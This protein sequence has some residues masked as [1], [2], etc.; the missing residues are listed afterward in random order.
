MPEQNREL[1]SALSSLEQN[2]IS[3]VNYS[4]LTLALRGLESKDPITRIAI[5]QSGATGDSRRLA[6]LLLADPLEEEQDWELKLVENDADARSLLITY[7]E[8]ADY[9]LSNPLLRVLSVPAPVL[10]K[11]RIEI[12]LLN[13]NAVD[14]SLKGGRITTEESLVTRVETPISTTGRYSQV[15]YPVHKAVTIGSGLTGIRN[16][17]SLASE[18]PEG[19]VRRMI[20]A[21]VDVPWQNPE[22]VL[23]EDGLYVIS[24][25][26]AEKA[27]AEIRQ[28]TSQSISYEHDW[29][30]SKVADI[31]GFMLDGTLPSTTVKPAHRT[32]ISN[33]ISNAQE[34]LKA[35][36]AK[37]ASTVGTIEDVA[38]SL[39]PLED[40]ISDW[41]ERAHTELRD[42]L[43]NAFASR[44]WRKLAWYKL[45]F[46]VDDVSMIGSDIIARSYLGD[47]EKGLIWL[48]GR[49]E[50][51]GLT[52]YAKNFKLRPASADSPTRGLFDAIPQPGTADLMASRDT[53]MIYFRPGLPWPQHITASRAQLLATALPSLQA[54]AQT[55][56]LQAFSGSS[57]AT[58]IGGLA[59]TMISTTGLYE[60]GAVTAFGVAITIARFQKLWDQAK[61][62]FVKEVNEEGKLVLE[63]AEQGCMDVVR[64][65]KSPPVDDTAEDR[66][67]ARQAITRAREVL[68]ELK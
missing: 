39:K 51:A 49:F 24:F 44:S 59:Y 1:H 46:R 27:L 8:T 35:H 47:A 3:Y 67:R 50:Q 29:I 68:E 26:Q 23:A 9:D 37:A 45:P 32:L 30:G 4:Q 28:S 7:A 10:Q 66:N 33:I 20:T 52:E 43:A 65:K 5:R 38:Q 22:Q 17:P 11:N 62:R 16:V 48:A 56:L 57:I 36:D 19:P 13:P 15:T 60:A 58:A 2:A 25:A 42:E 53:P 41:S 64:T 34:A 63:E 31:N 14:G 61:S 21:A 54:R 12:L 40:T 6:R 55:L 18:E